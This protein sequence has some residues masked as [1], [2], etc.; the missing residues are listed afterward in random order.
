MK[1]KK[2]SKNHPILAFFQKD[3][4]QTVEE[5]KNKVIIEFTKKSQ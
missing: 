3:P 5:I 1:L 4:L 2:L